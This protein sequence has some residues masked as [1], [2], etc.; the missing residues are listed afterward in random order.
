M[1]L[2]LRFFTIPSQFVDKKKRPAVI[3]TTGLISLIYYTTSQAT[4]QPQ[5]RP[6]MQL[7]PTKP[8]HR[9][10]TAPQSPP[11][12]PPASV[13]PNKPAHNGS[14]N[15]HDYL[16]GQTQ[17]A[18]PSPN[19]CKKIPRSPNKFHLNHPPIAKRFNSSTQSHNAI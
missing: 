12:L 6:S 10:K 7:R 11:P 2:F 16:T 5:N 13:Q 8:A 15:K 4:N 19:T 1:H 17:R 18:I 3:A 14:H 9:C